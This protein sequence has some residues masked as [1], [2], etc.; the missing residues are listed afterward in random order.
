MCGTERK[1]ID[2]I[3]DIL[4]HLRDAKQAAKEEHPN[5][6]FRAYCEKY[7]L[8]ST[9]LEIPLTLEF[10]ICTLFY[11]TKGDDWMITASEEEYAAALD[12]AINNIMEE[13]AQLD[14]FRNEFKEMVVQLRGQRRAEHAAVQHYLAEVE[15][16]WQ[17]SLLVQR[18]EGKCIEVVRGTYAEHRRFCKRR[19]THGDYCRQH[20][21]MRRAEMA[22]PDNSDDADDSDA[23]DISPR[24]N[25]AETPESSEPGDG[26]LGP[27]D[28]NQA[29]E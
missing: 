2:E 21:M 13:A 27:W 16:D 5:S 3:L 4:K 11:K 15:A 10:L 8:W 7:S 18:D 12:D 6:E 20:D 19:A 25:S 28:E 22:P 17:T 29:H 9:I 24:W 1:G 14:N 23:A 26:C